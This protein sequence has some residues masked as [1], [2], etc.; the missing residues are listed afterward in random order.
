MFPSM[1][2]YWRMH[3]YISREARWK[4]Y[5]FGQNSTNK[6]NDTSNIEVRWCSLKSQ[7][8]CIG[9]AGKPSKKLENSKATRKNRPLSPLWLYPSILSLHSSSSTFLHSNITLPAIFEALSCRI[10]FQELW[11]WFCLHTYIYAVRKCLHART[12]WLRHVF[13]F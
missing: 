12:H 6:L 8:N 10:T 3:I 7:I 2:V 1:H 5:L 4:A 9:K 11:E 13:L